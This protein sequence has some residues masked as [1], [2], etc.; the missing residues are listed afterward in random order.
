MV[1]V[2]PLGV[3]PDWQRRG[4]GRMLLDRTAALAAM[5]GHSALV[6]CGD[7]AHYS[8]RGFVSAETY[9]IRTADDMF[10]DALQLRELSPGAL[11]GC[12]GTYHESPDYAIN[13][14][15]VAA[16][17]ASFTPKLKVEGTP[18]QLRFR[19]MLNTM[20]PR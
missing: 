17:D 6:L 16:F 14:A 13:E 10:F 12:A 2:G 4:I 11:K 7:P 18:T 9:G 3:L 19:Q 15:D 20:R 1:T 8:H 5:E